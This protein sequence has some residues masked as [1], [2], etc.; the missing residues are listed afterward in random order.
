VI[1]ASIIIAGLVHVGEEFDSFIGGVWLN[2]PFRPNPCMAVSR[3]ALANVTTET[4]GG[5][6]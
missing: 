5:A 4:S 1:K 2:E 6:G 3:I